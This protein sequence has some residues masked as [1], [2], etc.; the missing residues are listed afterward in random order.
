MGRRIRTIKPEFVTD[1]KLA[2]CDD[3]TRLLAAC[4]IPM[5]DCNGNGVGHPGIIAGE[6]WGQHLHVTPRG[7]DTE[8]PRGFR[9]TGTDRLCNVLRSKGAGLLSLVELG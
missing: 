9:G 8:V 7:S 2:A 1:P 3:A 4:L 6:V 5:S